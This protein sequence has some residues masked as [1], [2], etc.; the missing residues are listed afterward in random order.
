L[1]AAIEAQG[2]PIELILTPGQEHDICQAP[3]LLADHQPK[4]A[5]ADKAYDDDSF[6]QRI[7]DR[8]AT[9]VIPSR[10]NRCEQRRLNKRQYRRRNLA[11]RFVNKIKHFRRIATRYEK[12]ACSFLGFVHFAAILCWL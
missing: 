9:A 6:V 8:G 3:H 2:R 4:Y 5:I 1:H 12:T 7:E 10:K 11:E